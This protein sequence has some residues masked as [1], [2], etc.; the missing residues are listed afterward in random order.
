[1]YDSSSLSSLL[2]AAD[3]FWCDEVVISVFAITG[4]TAFSWGWLS[5]SVFSSSCV[6]RAVAA[7]AACLTAATLQSEFSLRTFIPCDKAE[8]RLPRISA[9]TSPTARVVWG[10]AH[11]DAQKNG[12]ECNRGKI[13]LSSFSRKSRRVCRC[14]CSSSSCSPALEAVWNKAAELWWIHPDAFERLQ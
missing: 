11:L 8:A 2:P 12:E 1:M 14:R 13:S 3:L 7:A 9:E 4:Y 10:R 6:L 5:V